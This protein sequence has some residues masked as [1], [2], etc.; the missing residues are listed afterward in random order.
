MAKESDVSEE[1]PTEEAPSVIYVHVCG[2]VKSPGLYEFPEG[3]RAWDAILAA[4]GFAQEAQEDYLNLAAVLKDGQKL[5]VPKQGETVSEEAGGQGDRIDLNAADAKTLCTL[6]GIG[7][8]RAQAI[9]KYRKEHG[10]FEKTEDLM[11]VP[12]IKEGLYE[13]IKEFVVV[14]DD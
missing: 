1:E 3:T 4:G 8:T 13:Q 10:N 5:Y 2:A 14:K 9:L 11:K 6:P 7:E 12:G